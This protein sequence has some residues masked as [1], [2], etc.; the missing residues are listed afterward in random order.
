MLIT[1]ILTY[2]INEVNER[3]V[4]KKMQ[5]YCHGYV[6]Q[7][8]LGELTDMMITERRV[9]FEIGKQSTTVEIDTFGVDLEEEEQERIDL[10][11]RESFIQMIDSPIVVDDR[12]VWLKEAEMNVQIAESQSE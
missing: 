3:E 8:I 12:E 5:E 10:A 2:Q 4:S 9:E 1:G 6:E 7:T 11:V